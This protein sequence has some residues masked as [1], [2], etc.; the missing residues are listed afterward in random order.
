MTE[1]LLAIALLASPPV[2]EEPGPNL[3]ID[4]PPFG[5]LMF[6]GDCRM[7]ARSSVIDGATRIGCFASDSGRYLGEV[8]FGNTAWCGEELARL[9][10]VHLFGT[11]LGPSIVEI[12]DIDEV[13]YL[14]YMEDDVGCY[15]A[16]STSLEF[17]QLFG[18]PFE[19]WRC[20]AAVSSGTPTTGCE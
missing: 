13:Q 7:Y 1:L 12:M 20:D 17:V 9:G 14:F 5:A 16:K 3:W 6:P 19:K 15:L 2:V 11:Y 10:A 18:A 4:V 8:R